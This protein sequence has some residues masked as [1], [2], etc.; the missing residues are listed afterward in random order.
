METG[1]SLEFLLRL[2]QFSSMAH[3]Y[4]L[5]FP[6]QIFLGLVIFFS[7]SLTIV[8]RLEKRSIWPYGDLHPTPQFSDTSGYGARAVS[9]A[10]AQGFTF[11]GWTLDNRGSI[12][13]LNFAMLVSP[14]R[15]AFMVVSEGTIASMRLASISLFTPTIDGRS[16]YST[17]NQASVQLDLSR[18]WIS[19]YVPLANFDKL[20]RTHLDWLHKLQITPRPFTPGNEFSELRTLREQHFR[21]MERAG[22]VRFVESSP[23]NFYF[24]TSGAAKTAISGYFLGMARQ[25]SQGRFPRSI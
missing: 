21:A 25:L 14:D 24:T 15:T 19:Q 4:L 8:S 5:P 13:K 2:L 12:Y 23:T 17:N 18:N 10:V 1:N 20:L 9:D 11:L 6:L 16:F 22:L 7:I 3:F